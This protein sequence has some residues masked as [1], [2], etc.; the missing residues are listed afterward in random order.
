MA[1]ALDQS[2]SNKSVNHPIIRLDFISHLRV[3]L[4]GYNFIHTMHESTDQ[5]EVG[6]NDVFLIK[7]SDL[8]TQNYIF[9]EDFGQLKILIH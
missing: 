4:H 2:K 9:E 1:S 7:P 6:F 8:A 3:K 5:S